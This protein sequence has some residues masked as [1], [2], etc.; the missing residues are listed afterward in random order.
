[1]TLADWDVAGPFALGT[2]AAPGPAAS[3]SPA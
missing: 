3:R 1:M 2:F